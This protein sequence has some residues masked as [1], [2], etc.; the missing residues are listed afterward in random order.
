MSAPASTV[1]R[2][3]TKRPHLTHFLMIP[4]GHIPDLRDRVSLFTNALLATEPVIAGLDMSVIIPPRR[5]HL[6]LGVLSLVKQQSQ[7]KDSSQTTINAAV[8]LLH[9]LK[10]DLDRAVCPDGKVTVPLVAM[11]IMRSGKGKSTPH[12]LHIGPSELEGTALKRVTDVVYHAFKTAGLLQDD[13]PL[14]LHCT[15]VNTIY[16]KPRSKSRIPF[17]YASI[18]QSAAVASILEPQPATR[19]SL[20]APP[21]DAQPEAAAAPTSR[22]DD[23]RRR[24]NKPELHIDLG[25]WTVDEVQLCEM[26]SHAEDGAYVCVGSVPLFSG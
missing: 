8:D 7:A 17:D 12:V 25:V 20:A 14:K 11:D 5:L 2:A 10:S 4:L 22:K 19:Q 6:T 26:G 13:R 23:G 15:V 3:A 21:E 24:L 16:R 1:A 18:R 9:R